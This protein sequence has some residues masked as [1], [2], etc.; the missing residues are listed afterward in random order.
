MTKTIPT[1]IGVLIIILV[2]G[3]AGA[4][5]LLF[6]QDVEEEVVL[7]EKSFIE[8]DETD[9][10]EEPEIEDDEKTELEI[11]P[12]AEPEPEKDEKIAEEEPEK[13][14]KAMNVKIP[15]VDEDY[16]LF[17][18]AKKYHTLQCP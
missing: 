16:K 4:S 15:L 12:E 17:Y 7:E 1:T 14:E 6:S 3:V 13:D 11:Y 18:M 10:G 9:T 2:A 5:V 8:E